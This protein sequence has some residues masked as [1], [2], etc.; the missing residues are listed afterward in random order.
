MGERQSD[1]REEG[2]RE[3]D[4]TISQQRSLC[5]P[6]II[7]KELTLKLD[8]CSLAYWRLLPET[9]GSKKDSGR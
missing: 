4:F 1:R 8:S 6:I 9:Q 3:T 7:M 2:E 5:L